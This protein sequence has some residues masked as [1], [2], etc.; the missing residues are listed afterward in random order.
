MNVYGRSLVELGSN[1]PTHLQTRALETTSVQI[2]T[3]ESYFSLGIETIVHIICPQCSFLYAPMLLSVSQKLTYPETCS[4]QSPPSSPPCNTPL[5]DTRGRPLKTF[6]YYPFF[7]WF[8]Q[9][10]AQPNIQQYGKAFCDDVC[11]SPVAPVDKVHTSDGDVY[12]QLLGPDGRLFVDGGEE[13]RFVFLFHEDGFNTEG[14]TGRGKTRHTGIS[15]LKC[16]NLPYHLRNDDANVYIPGFIRGPNLPDAIDAHYRHLL[17]PFFADLEKAYTRGVK[18]MGSPKPESPTVP[19]P[20]T[21]FRVMVAGACMDLKATRPVSGLLDVTS[22]HICTTCS[23]F[24]QESK[25]QTDH[26]NWSPA[27]DAAFREGM[28]KWVE[29]QTTKER[30]MIED[31][32]ATRYGPLVI[33]KYFNYSS[34]LIADPMHTFFHRIMQV[35]FRQALCL[36]TLD[37]KVRPA[38]ISNIAFHY[39]FAHIPRPSLETLNEQSGEEF[40]AFLEWEDLPEDESQIRLSR[41]QDWLAKVMQNR[42]HELSDIVKGHQLLSGTRPKRSSERKRLIKALGGLHWHSLVY[43]CNDLWIYPVN[44][45]LDQIQLSKTRAFTRNSMAQALAEWVRSDFFVTSILL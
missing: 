38:H 29:A 20:E 11:K 40:L 4:N 31:Y 23:L 1:P 21:V 6:E 36:S 24:H 7:Q 41:I 14:T 25:W 44:T 3:A 5:L 17:K 37:P 19:G 33:L 10:V 8:A 28:Q 16:L 26:E 13:C 35:Y 12:R 34:Q 32:Y 30:E 22:H 43:I 45:L 27:D 42:T 2:S 39:D 15:S 18:C 9:W